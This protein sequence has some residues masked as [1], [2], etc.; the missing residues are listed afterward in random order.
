[1]T[2]LFVYAANSH[3]QLLKTMDM[4]YVRILKWIAFNI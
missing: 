1:M 2:Y 4:N 3:W